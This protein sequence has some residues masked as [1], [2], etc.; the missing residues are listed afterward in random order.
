LGD[1][2][3]GEGRIEEIGNFISGRGW[4]EYTATSAYNQE[5]DYHKPLR[6]ILEERTREF[7][8]VMDA[9]KGGEQGLADA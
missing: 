7:K 1:G 2:N 3:V 6:S 4:I 8:S 9:K 5:I